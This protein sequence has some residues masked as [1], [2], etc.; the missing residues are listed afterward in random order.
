MVDGEER[1]WDLVNAL[2][3]KYA[4]GFPKMAEGNGGSLEVPADCPVLAQC[5]EGISEDRKISY[6]SQEATYSTYSNPFVFRL[7]EVVPRHFVV[8]SDGRGR[9]DASKGWEQ[10][11]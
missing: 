1:W 11:S 8:M 3:R 9:M 5:P 4:W 6:E 10:T 7:G 2:K